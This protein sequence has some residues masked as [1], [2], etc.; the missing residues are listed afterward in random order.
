MLSR[1]DTDL[2]CRIGPGTPMGALMRRYWMPVLYTWEI[3]PDGPATTRTRARRR[4]HCLARL[5]WCAQFR[6]GELPAP[7]RVAV[8]RAQ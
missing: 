7:R 2:L 6:L 4:S 1:E 8:L 5:Q 3:E